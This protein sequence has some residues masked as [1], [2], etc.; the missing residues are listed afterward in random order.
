MQED[1]PDSRIYGSRHFDPPVVLDGDEEIRKFTW[2]RGADQV[3]IG[4]TETII[5]WQCHRPLIIPRLRIKARE[6]VEARP[7]CPPR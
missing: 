1:Y 4:P 3:E 5:R 7:Q 6:K 2:I